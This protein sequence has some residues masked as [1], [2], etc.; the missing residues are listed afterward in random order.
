LIA[1]RLGTLAFPAGKDASAMA[2]FT[3]LPTTVEDKE[4]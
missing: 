3:A 4:E 1:A 2:S